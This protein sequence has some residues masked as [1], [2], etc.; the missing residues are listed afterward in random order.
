MRRSQWW[1]VLLGLV[2]TA[3]IAQV[4]TPAQLE[5]LKAMP[6][7]Q[8]DALLQQYG[9]DPSA[10]EAGEPAA[11]PNA[12]PAAAAAAADKKEELQRAAEALTLQ[13]GDTVLVTVSAKAVA[14][15]H[16][17][18]GPGRC[19]PSWQ[20][21]QPRSCR[22]TGSSRRDANRRGRIDRRASKSSSCARANV[23][24]TDCVDQPLACAACWA[25][26]PEALRLRSV[27]RRTLDVCAAH[28]RARSGR[29]RR[30]S[31]RPVLGSALRQP[32]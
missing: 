1:S 6:A 17:L 21:L 23:A 2:C 26:R 13:P 16:C 9:V 20:S 22:A 7:A 11:A 28:R 29:L 15:G 24:I 5:M 19:N 31:W 4:P 10:L 3:A 8:R 27:R 32:E 18:H 25:P 14:E 30:G 12:T